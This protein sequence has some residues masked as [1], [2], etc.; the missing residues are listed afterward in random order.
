MMRPQPPDWI[1]RREFGDLDCR[2]I[3]PIMEWDS[4]SECLHGERVRVDVIRHGRVEIRYDDAPLLVLVW[5]PQW[6]DYH[7]LRHDDLTSPLRGATWVCAW[8]WHPSYPSMQIVDFAAHQSYFYDAIRDCF[9]ARDFDFATRTIA[10]TI[11]DGY[12]Y[13]ALCATLRGETDAT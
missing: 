12:S 5:W 9:D 8:E 3:V 2:L 13:D 10:R 4:S 1:I 6:G 7:P 11:R